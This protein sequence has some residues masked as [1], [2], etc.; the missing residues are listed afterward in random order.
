MK[1]SR[2][3]GRG[4]ARVPDLFV[5][6]LLLG[7]LP[8]GRRRELEADPEVRRRAAELEASNAR[9]LAQYPAE[10]MARRIEERLRA[11]RGARP[12]GELRP[13]EASAAL[14]P[15]LAP[16]L[17][18]LPAAGFAALFVAAGLLTFLLVPGLRDRVAVTAAQAQHPRL[19]GDSAHLVLFRQTPAGVQPLRRGAVARPGEV[20]RIGYTGARG[21]HGVIVSLDG[22]GAL[23]VH[24]PA[25]G[26][27]SAPLAAESAG[28][29]ESA[30][31][32]GA[33]LPSAYELGDAPGPERFFLV[34]S[35]GPFDVQAVVAAVK[36][37]TGRLALP[38]GLEQASFLLRKAD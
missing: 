14:F 9:I 23:T 13:R 37:G 32:A 33:V 8:A 3:S 26:S 35:D 15:R 28:A 29:A 22:R 34:V 1:R 31:A 7:E 16:A 19:Q 18:L 20:L 24:F 36:S 12:H 11:A 38:P 4:S 25:A 30:D 17:R 10:D 27:V 2:R 6:Q 5:E 21:R